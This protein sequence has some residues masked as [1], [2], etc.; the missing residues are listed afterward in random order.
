MR[1]AIAIAFLTLTACGTAAP[2]SAS[3]DVQQ[4]GSHSCIEYSGADLEAWQK[5][6][7]TAK[8]TWSPAA[9]TRAHAVGGCRLPPENGISAT[10]WFYAPLTQAQ[11][12]Q[13]CSTNDFVNP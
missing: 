9:C 1:R 7:G 5:A 11:V 4:N 6:C 10:E 12:Q 2:E 13:S 3:C 8:G